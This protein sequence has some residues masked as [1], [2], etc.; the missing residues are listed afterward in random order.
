MKTAGMW[1]G[2][3]LMLAIALGSFWLPRFWF[4]Y[5]RGLQG[6]AVVLELTPHEHATVR[7]RYLVGKKPFQAQSTPEKPNPPL[8]QLHVGDSL[9]V[10][11]DPEQ[12]SSSVIQDP[13]R[14]FWEELTFVILGSMLASGLILLYIID[15]RTK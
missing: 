11:Y 5:Q 10:F 4:I 7:Y 12:P 13:V 8:E 15:R 3:A 14:L 6:N 1:F 9:V 2:L